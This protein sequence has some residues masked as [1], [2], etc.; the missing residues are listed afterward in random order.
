MGNAK[1]LLGAALEFSK[2]MVE[3]RKRNN[4]NQISSLPEWDEN[5]N[6]MVCQKMQLTNMKRIVNK[7]SNYDKKF[8]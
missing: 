7:I 3:S 6:K 5:L 2:K 4:H 8:K 1:F